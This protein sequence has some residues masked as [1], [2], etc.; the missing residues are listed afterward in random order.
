M[1]GFYDGGNLAAREDVVVVTINYRLGP[2]GWF[3]HA[4]LR[5]AAA[6]DLDRSGNF[7]TLDQVRALEWVRDN[8]AA[9]GG[10]P[11]NVTVFGESAGGTDVFALLLAP[12]A[13]GLFHRAIVESGDLAFGAPATAEGFVDDPQPSHPN[14]SGEAAARMLIAAGGAPDRVAAKAKLAAMSPEEIAAWL[15]SQPAYDVMR[16]FPI[17]RIGRDGRR[18]ARVPR[19]RGAPRRGSAGGTRARCGT[20]TRARDRRHESRRE[21]ALHV[22]QSRAGPAGGSA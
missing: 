1:P 17:G 5:D 15:R 18:A 2:F 11:G 3:R 7:G 20:R 22:R 16:A 14:A 6:S 10:D 19:R 4:A 8:A 21:Q 13:R 12:P 9:F